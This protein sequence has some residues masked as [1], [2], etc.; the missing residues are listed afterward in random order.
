M[1]RQVVRFSVALTVLLLAG[2]IRAQG[3]AA[4]PNNGSAIQLGLH[5]GYGVPFGKTGRTVT[6]LVDDDVSRS[7][8]G[9]IPIGLD[10]GYLII[11]SVYVGLSFQYGFGLVGSAGDPFCNQ[12]GVSCSVSDISVGVGAQ[13]H[14]DPTASFDPW[15]GLG[16]GYEWLELSTSSAGQN[17]SQTGSGFEYVTLQLGGDVRVAPSF[18]VG[19]FVSFSA[20][21]YLNVSQERPSVELSQGI[22]DKSFHEWLLFG[23]RGVYNVRSLAAL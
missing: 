21:Q 19:P 7:I 3:R 14:L 20:G 9:Q 1:I 13:Y 12:S 8:K 11:P 2:P 22:T 4:P 17:D 5:F 16:G 18:A 10:I 23:V 6:D 15:I